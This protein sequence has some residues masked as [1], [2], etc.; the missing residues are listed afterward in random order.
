MYAENAP[1]IFHK[2]IL[3]ALANERLH[4]LPLIAMTEL[5]AWV[6][7][8]VLAKDC[9]WR[10]VFANKS[11]E[12]DDDNNDDDDDGD[13]SPPPPKKKPTKKRPPSSGS[14]GV[15]PKKVSLKHVC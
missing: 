14:G 13:D 10:T 4:E 5:V 11:C 8:S 2:V 7:R 12:T 6:H 15:S 3:H 1:V 9:I